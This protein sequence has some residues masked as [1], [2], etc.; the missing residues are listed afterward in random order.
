MNLVILTESKV[1]LSL[2]IDQ[3]IRV[4][5]NSIFYVAFQLGLALPAWLVKE[6]N[7][8]LVLLVYTVA[9]GVILPFLVVR[10]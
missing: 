4:S 5:I 2:P 3:V 10:V 8:G 7:S 9:F 6:G 1:D